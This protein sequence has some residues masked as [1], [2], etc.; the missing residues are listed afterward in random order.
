[1]DLDGVLAL[2]PGLLERLIAGANVFVASSAAP[3]GVVELA[4]RYPRSQ[5]VGFVGEPAGKGRTAMSRGA[6]LRWALRGPASLA[7]TAR[8]D[9]V[10][11]HMTLGSDAT[12]ALERIHEAL[13]L[14]GVLLLRDRAVRMQAM[15]AA[16]LCDV[17]PRAGFL[18]ARRRARPRFA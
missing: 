17:R 11:V 13:R 2:L 10:V 9:L 18:V 15:L 14:E 7:D 3:A 5:F 4:A 6:N 8:F 16:G 12:D 1:M